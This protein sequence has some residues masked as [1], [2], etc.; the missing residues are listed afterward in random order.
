MSRK[1]MGNKYEREYH[2][3]S[4]FGRTRKPK[5]RLISRM[6]RISQSPLEKRERM[7]HKMRSFYPCDKKRYKGEIPLNQCVTVYNYVLGVNEL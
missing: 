7:Q 4:R 6:Y 3:K 2:A 1:Y 5:A